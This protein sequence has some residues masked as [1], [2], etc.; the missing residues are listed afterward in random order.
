MI[1]CMSFIT[2]VLFIPLFTLT[3]CKTKNENSKVAVQPVSGEIS[4]NKP[5][6][7][8]SIHEAALNGLSG[9]VTA[10]LAEGLNVNA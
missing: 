1:K 9:Q 10:L 8:F 6:P 7:N 2:L 4:N 5:K 3:D